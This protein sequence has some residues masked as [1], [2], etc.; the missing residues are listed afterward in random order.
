MRMFAAFATI[1]LMACQSPTKEADTHETAVPAD[2][3]SPVED[4]AS[5][6]QPDDTAEPTD[7]VYAS[8]RSATHSFSFV[9]NRNMTNGNPLKGFVTNIVN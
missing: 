8:E 1:L 7:S 2:S 5:P 3:D 6:T 4:S 9:Y